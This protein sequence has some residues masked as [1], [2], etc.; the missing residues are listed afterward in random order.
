[1]LRIPKHSE[2][3]QHLLVPT[4]IALNLTLPRLA[5]CRR[6]PKCDHPDPEIRV[7]IVRNDHAG[8]GLIGKLLIE[9]EAELGE[10][11]DRLIEIFYR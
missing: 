9:T 5:P 2:S 11:L 6:A 7:Y 4:L 8:G 1:M 10:K 3:F